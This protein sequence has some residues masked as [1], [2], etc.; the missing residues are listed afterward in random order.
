[1][2]KSNWTKAAMAVGILTSLLSTGCLAGGQHHRIVG[3][4]QPEEGL[5]Y[6]MEGSVQS[7]DLGLVADF[8]VVRLGSVFEGQRREIVGRG[9]EGGGVSIDQ[10]IELNAM[11]L[12][13]PLLSLTEFGSSEHGG[14]Y[15]G[16]MAQRHGL[17]VWLSGSVGTGPIQPASV[18]L[19]LSYYRYGGV[20]ARL[21]GGWSS[22]PYSGVAGGAIMDGGQS[23]RVEG[24]AQ[25]VVVGLEMTMAAGEYALEIARGILDID[26]ESRSTW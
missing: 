5:D 16:T 6:S 10:T 8:R 7:V 9:E 20:A 14:W 17:E 19:G 24:R 3:S 26:R 13:V 18:T 12:D 25:G 23:R 2:T 4:D 21:F 11:R 22:H 1:M 15:P